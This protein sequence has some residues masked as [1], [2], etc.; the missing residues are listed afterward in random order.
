MKGKETVVFGRFAH[1]FEDFFMVDL[2]YLGQMV[3]FSIK[4]KSSGV[5]LIHVFV[6][7]CPKGMMISGIFTLIKELLAL[8]GDMN[9]CKA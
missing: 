5:S 2:S 3:T 8:D 6:F 9:T 1:L 4:D 7:E